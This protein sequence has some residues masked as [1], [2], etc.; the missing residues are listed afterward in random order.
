MELYQIF[1]YKK[2]DTPKISES[3]SY[4]HQN[5]M[6]QKLRSAPIAII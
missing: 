1:S 5:L 3:L 2:Y 4:P 6:S